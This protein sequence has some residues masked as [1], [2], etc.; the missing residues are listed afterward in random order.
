MLRAVHVIYGDV[1]VPLEPRRQ[2]FPG[3]GQALTV[4][5]TFETLIVKTQS[6]DTSRTSVAS[7]ATA[8]VGVFIAAVENVPHQ[9]E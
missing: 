5:Y 1:T 3:R 2:F 7:L 6:P 8:V 4:P 9:G